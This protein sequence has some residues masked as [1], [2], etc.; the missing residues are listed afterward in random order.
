MKNR[1]LNETVNKAIH[2]QTQDNIDKTMTVLKRRGFKEDPE[3]IR[4]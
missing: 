3:I 4:K 1:K 2:N